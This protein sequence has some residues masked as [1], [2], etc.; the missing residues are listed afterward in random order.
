[1]IATTELVGGHAT[2]NLSSYR[3]Y[4]QSPTL[5]TS[6]WLLGVT[7]AVIKG[8]RGTNYTTGCMSLC[9]STR[10]VVEG[11]C[12]GIGCCETAIPRG[13]MD[14]NISVFSYYN[15]TRVWEFNPCS[16][17]FVAEAG[18]YNFSKQD[19]RNLKDQGNKMPMLLNW[20]IGDQ[21]C[22]ELKRVLKV[23]H[24]WLTVIVMTR[25]MVQATS[26][27]VPKDTKAIL[28]LRMA[29]KVAILLGIIV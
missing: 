2:I 25:T 12:S 22:R 11:S 4:S 28:T 15:H 23:M 14:F 10:N 17:A 26:A 8:S 6:S 1:M 29:A 16:Y 27:V 13:V 19:L 24:A 5:E 7:Y 18:T 20:A 21:N 9:D 3:E